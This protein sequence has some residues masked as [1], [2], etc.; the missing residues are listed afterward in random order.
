MMSHRKRTERDDVDFGCT[1][2]ESE[3]QARV[4]PPRMSYED[5][6]AFLARW[7]PPSLDELRDKPG[8]QGER[9]RLEF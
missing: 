7:P 5:Y 6:F 1:P 9:F 8:P 3:A 2:E 4:G